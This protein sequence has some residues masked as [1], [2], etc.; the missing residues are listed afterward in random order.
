[1]DP[2]LKT[3]ASEVQIFKQHIAVLAKHHR[4]Q[5]MP[6]AEEAFASKKLIHDLA[7]MVQ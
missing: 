3:D 6:S 1:M 2:E 5:R 7:K 4:M